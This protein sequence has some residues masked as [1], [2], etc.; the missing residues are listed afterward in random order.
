MTYRSVGGL[1]STYS[2]PFV[3]GLEAHA[4]LHYDITRTDR[5]TFLPSIL[6]GQLKSGQRGSDYRA[7]QSQ[8]NNGLE[9]YLSYAPATTI[10]PGNV[11]LTGGYSYGQSHAE[12][13]WYLATGLSTDLLVGNGVASA[14]TTQNVQDVQESR[15]ISFFGR[16][17]YNLHDRYLLAASVR[18]DGSSR[19]GTGNQW[20]VFP[21]VSAGWRLSEEGFLSGIRSISDLKLRASWAKTGNQAFAN[22]QQYAQ[23]VLGDGQTRVQFGSEYV[24]SLRPS[25]YDP[26]IKWEATKATDVGLDFGFWNQRLTGALDWY[27]KKTD[28]LIFT[29]PIAAGTN[30]SNYLTTNIGSMKNRGVELSLSTPLR[31]GGNGAFSWNLDFVAAYNDNELVSIN[32][33]FGANVQLQRILTGLV[34][35]GVGTN[36]QVLQPGQP[37]NSF[38]VYQHRN[39]ANGKPVFKEGAGADTAMYIDQNGDR[40]INQDDRVPFQSPNPK[41]ILGHT[42]SLGFRQFDLSFTLR[43][44]LGNY[45][46]NN[47]SSNLG[48]YSEVT[49]ASPYNLH[50]SVLETGFKTPQ[51]LSDY[52]VE[53]A[54]FLRMDNITLGRGFT[55]RGQPLRASLTV[56]NVF[57]STGYSGVDPTAGLNGLDNNIYPRSR[58]YS[59]GLTVRF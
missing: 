38:F 46:Y 56:Q 31:R 30:L 26:D 3:E 47:V 29:V 17:N 53:D 57:T 37:I 25:A 51:Y 6:H 50:A 5:Q 16:F 55:Y 52:Y 58:T 34:S 9:T 40:V 59:A 49:R 33:V 2:L 45:V 24:P 43:A 21:S 22:Y 36:I 11:D 39:G 15:L 28:N 27:D 7:N 32:P 54:S 41:W 8:T 13:P 18:R 20:G 14:L 1:Q 44:Y 4:N 12:Y 48:T 10:I 35:G 23:Y 42:S 19:F